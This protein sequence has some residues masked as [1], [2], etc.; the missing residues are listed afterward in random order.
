MNNVDSITATPYQLTEWNLQYVP[1]PEGAIAPNL[2]YSIPDTLGTWVSNQQ[3]KSDTLHVGV[4]FA[5]VSQADFDSVAVKVILFDTLQNPIEL[6][7]QRV[8]ALLAGD[9]LHIDLQLPVNGLSGWYNMYL[10]VN[11]AGDQPEQF[12]FNNFLYKYIYF[13]N[14]TSL[15]VTLTSFTALLQG[16]QVK[17]S[18]NVSAEVNTRQYEVEYSTSGDHFNRISTVAAAGVAGKNEYTYYHTNPA[19]GF[20]YYRLKIIDKD[21]SFTYSAIRQVTVDPSVVI[22]L[23]PNPVRDVLTLSVANPAAKTSEVILLNAFGQQVWQK[24]MSGTEQIDMK[25]LPAG[26]YLLR[27]LTNGVDHVYKVQKQ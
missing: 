2:Y 18:W 19:N 4:A 27:V 23:Y 12:T 17:T 21:G 15:P 25:R 9:S 7:L 6:P 22:R 24:Q 16:T 14:A 8:R 1:V 10:N 20:N 11:P 5:N 13:D 3:I 26:N